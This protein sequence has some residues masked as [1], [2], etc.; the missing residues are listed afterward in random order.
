M[1]NYLK[2]I[3]VITL[4]TFLIL[5]APYIPD[6]VF[7]IF[8]ATSCLIVIIPLA[9]ITIINWK[10]KIEEKNKRLKRIK[11]ICLDCFDDLY[12]SIITE[13]ADLDYCKKYVNNVVVES[14][15]TCRDR[16][17]LTDKEIV[18]INQMCEEYYNEVKKGKTY[19]ND[20]TYGTNSQ[21]RWFEITQEDYN[22]LGYGKNFNKTNK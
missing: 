17:F 10:K 6:W 14:L 12:R 7:E 1:L 15:S 19:R 21:I 4:G 16:A 3:I 9:T 22:K 5:M 11:S 20:T 2:Y 8:I 13:K 18:L